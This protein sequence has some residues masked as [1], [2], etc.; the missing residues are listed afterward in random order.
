MALTPMK[1]NSHV[2]VGLFTVFVGALI[3]GVI[4][5]AAAVSEPAAVVQLPCHV[6]VHVVASPGSVQL[7]LIPHSGDATVPVV[8]PNPSDAH[9]PLVMLFQ[10]NRCGDDQW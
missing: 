3:A 5:G 9:S 4:A 6:T 10:E 8:V 2:Q 1:N 7:K